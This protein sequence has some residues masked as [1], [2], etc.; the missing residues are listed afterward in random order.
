MARRKVNIEV[1]VT[2]FSINDIVNMDYEFIRQLSRSQLSK[3]TSRLVSA[4]N[5]RIRILK[6]S[7]IGSHSYALHNLLART[8][9]EKLSV[10]GKT[11]GQIQNVFSIA[12]NFLTSKTSTVRGFKKVLKNM[13]TTI[14]SKTGRMVSSVDVAKL[15]NTLHRGQELGIIEP[16]Q[17]Q[18]S[19]RAV[20]MIVELMERNPNRTID[21][22]I[23][24]LN[25]WYDEMETR[26]FE[27]D[28]EEYDTEIDDFDFL[29]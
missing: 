16:P 20:G 28:A 1:D 11:Q 18:G 15:F 5:K 26:M 23:D 27:D 21:E 2:G 25:N 3:L 9:G 6:K 22:L 19:E 13:R 10:K 12:K 17:T 24:D 8:G 7:D 4:T 14:E 29:Q